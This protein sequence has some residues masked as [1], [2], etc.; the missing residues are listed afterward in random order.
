MP[1]VRYGALMT[2]TGKIVEVTPPAGIE[3]I[4]KKRGRNETA[5]RET[6]K[7]FYTRMQAG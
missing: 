1:G 5:K 7:N 4:Q 2:D 3:Q 6:G